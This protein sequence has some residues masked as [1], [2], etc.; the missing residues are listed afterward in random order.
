MMH[1]SRATPD[2]D[3]AVLQRYATLPVFSAGA[4]E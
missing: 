2:H 3:I 1:S 4:S